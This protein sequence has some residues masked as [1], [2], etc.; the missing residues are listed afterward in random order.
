MAKQIIPT[1]SKLPWY[2][3]SK[4]KNKD[5]IQDTYLVACWEYDDE[6]GETIGLLTYP[7]NEFSD[8]GSLA[9]LSPPPNIYRA[10]VKSGVWLNQAA[11]CF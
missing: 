10:M 7:I 4:E 6:S 5:G 3:I 2:W 9:K 8:K 11:S 1:G